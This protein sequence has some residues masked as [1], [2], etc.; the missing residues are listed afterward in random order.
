VEIWHIFL[1]VGILCQEQSDNPAGDDLYVCN[2]DHEFIFQTEAQSYE[3]EFL[4]VP[5]AAM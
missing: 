2:N 3:S 1:R 4:S 5:T